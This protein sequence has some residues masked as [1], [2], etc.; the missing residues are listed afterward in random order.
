MD[1]VDVRA[2]HPILLVVFHRAFNLS[3]NAA[4]TA[5]GLSQVVATQL[6]DAP[7]AVFWVLAITLVLRYTLRPQA[8]AVADAAASQP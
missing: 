4:A 2:L 6:H 7:V 8:R 5:L 3:F 1:P